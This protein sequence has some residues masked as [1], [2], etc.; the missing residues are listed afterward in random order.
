MKKKIENKIKDS[1]NSVNFT[2]DQLWKHKDGSMELIPTMPTSKIKK[3]LLPEIEK[4]ISEKT[5]S[6]QIFNQKKIE[7][8][9]VLITR[10][11]LD[12][13]HSYEEK[14]HA[15]L[16]SIPTEILERALEFVLERDR[17][18]YNRVH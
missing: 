11:E 18:N 1:S 16:I 10:G 8:E 3:I 2:P 12:P 7:C 4:R 13:S 6:V 14:M 5:N 17:V 9:R 15:L